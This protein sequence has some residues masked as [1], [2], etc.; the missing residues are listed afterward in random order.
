MTPTPEVQ[1]KLRR[2]LLGQLAED[3]RAEVEKDLLAND[4]LFE[5]LLV[6]EDEIIDEYLA[7]KL[8]MNDRAAFAR[9][10]LVTPERQEQVNFARAFKRHLAGNKLPVRS[11]WP[12]FLYKQT[13]ATRAAL[14]VLMVAI[15]VGGVWLLNGRRSAPQSFATLTLTASQATRSEGSEVPR[16]K[17]PLR[18]S[19]LRLVLILPEGSASGAGYRAVI[20]TVLGTT[21]T[22]DAT[23]QDDRSVTVTVPANE[24]QRGDYSIKLFAR[25]PDGTERRISGSYV[26]TLE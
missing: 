11:F 20:E 1:E 9:H 17:L 25:Y 26:F 13:A 4:E 12:G 22:L 3:A 24:L 19:N 14:I 2:Y 7:E 5:E 15:V 10:F 18:E 6:L 21:K 23:S 8:T 16:L